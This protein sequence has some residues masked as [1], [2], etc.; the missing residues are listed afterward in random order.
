MRRAPLILLTLG[1]LVT[2]T[3]SCARNA[4][5]SAVYWIDYDHGNDTADGLTKRTAWKHLPGDEDAQGTAGRHTPGPGERFVLVA[6]T[7]YRGAVHFAFAGR[8]D[9]P[10][11]IGSETGGPPA[12]FDGSDPVADARPCR[13]GAEC[14]DA[15][16]WQ[17]LTRISLAGPSDVVPILFSDQ[18]PLSE[19][20]SP[21]PKD[22]FY[23]DEVS[24]FLTMDSHDLADGQISV[25][26]ALAATLGRPG[27]RVVIW[28][29][30]NKV[31]ERPLTAVNGTQVSFDPSGVDFYMDRP[32]RIAFRGGVDQID[33][34]GE[35][36]LL[37]DRR[38]VVAWLPA[39]AGTLSAGSGRSGIDVSGSSH[40]IVRDLVFERFADN[41]TSIRSGIGV[42]A[43]GKP[44]DDLTVE[45]NVFR[46]FVSRVGQGAVIVQHADGLV[47][48]GNTIKN[49]QF[50]SGM[51][52]GSSKNVTVADNE[53]SR[54]GR[55]GI[56]LM[57]DT[58]VN[59]TSNRIHDILGLHG[60]G[61]SAYLSN[62]NVR[63]V[64]NTVFDAKQPVTYHGSKGDAQPAANIA[65][66]H[67]VFIATDEALGSLISW[68]AGG[69]D[70][71]KISN[72]VIL[73]GAKVA[74][75]M[76]G[77]DRSVTISNNIIAGMSVNGEVPSD[78]AIGGNAFTRAWRGAIPAG[79][80]T[81]SS[82][83]VGPGGVIDP[84]AVCATI[85]Q[86]SPDT[87]ATFARAL[88]AKASC[89]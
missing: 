35:F 25:P 16:N 46:D 71:V 65:F 44:L 30:S 22:F 6:G 81:V 75:R 60:N 89:P 37:P 11:T 87:D 38:T 31:V 32:S 5:A 26:P 76:S 58:D 19:A 84:A 43:Q 64:A 52:L 29:R 79:N 28:V 61:M 67:N 51:R 53:I 82:V 68:N 47:V 24:Q 55:T 86:P 3:V 72:N 57:N 12:I 73:G 42:S 69:V 10:I 18:G 4:N 49:M 54:I 66:L 7:R 33:Q 2:A 17:R 70:G 39:N 45:A 74:L 62:R 27:T 36:S 21:N 20:Q 40:V 14:G 63:F 15:P 1:V 83:R 9:A 78:W 41:G 77:A 34:P 88:G 8:K 80:R 59:V 85:T 13:N 50:G 48:R 23:G 56:M